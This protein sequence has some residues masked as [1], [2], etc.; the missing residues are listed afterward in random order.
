M[1]II[2]DN[3]GKGLKAFGGT[4]PSHQIFVIQYHSWTEDK[5][6][7]SPAAGE[8]GSS[9]KVRDFRPSER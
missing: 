1:I 2:V 9:D 5:L 7:Q 8:R 6:L 3:G 4:V